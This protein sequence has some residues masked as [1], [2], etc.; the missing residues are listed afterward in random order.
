MAAKH[1]RV[2]AFIQPMPI[3]ELLKRLLFGARI[4]S[5]ALAAVN[6]IPL[7]ALLTVAKMTSGDS[8][9]FG[10]S[11]VDENLHHVLERYLE[12][13]PDALTADFGFD[14][15]IFDM[16]SD[17]PLEVDKRMPKDAVHTMPLEAMLHSHVE[18]M[19]NAG[20]ST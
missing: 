15:K 16:R 19:S 1:P 18:K 4:H 14:Y 5:Q 11:V 2:K 13:N 9:V 17:P 6:D 3:K 7:P 10:P 12:D 20:L 8:V